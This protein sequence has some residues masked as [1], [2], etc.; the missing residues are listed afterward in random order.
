M[1]TEGFIQGYAGEEVSLLVDNIKLLGIQNVSWKATQSKSAIRG[2]GHKKAHGIGRGVKEYELDFEVKELNQAVISEA[3]NA[4]RGNEEQSATFR[5]GDQ[6]FSD[7]LDLR[8]VTI[9]VLYPAKNNYR[10]TAKFTGFEFTDV[11]G[12]FAFDDESVGRK[13]S[14]IALDAS[15]LV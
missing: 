12:G 4:A 11:E 14:G 6:E 2:A 5:I 10:R 13:L 9:L 8:N 1:A 15:G 7:L 3:V